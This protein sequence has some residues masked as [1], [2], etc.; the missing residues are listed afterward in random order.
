MWMIIRRRQYILEVDRIEEVEEI[1]QFSK[2]V[3][4]RSSS[5]QDS[6]DRIQCLE[7]VEDRIGIRFHW[8]SA[9]QGEAS[10]S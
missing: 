4:E 3:V 5:Q 9:L 6:M 7:A 1:K 2:V 8:T 10:D